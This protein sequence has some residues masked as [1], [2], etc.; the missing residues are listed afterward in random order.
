M[1]ITRIQLVLLFTIEEVLHIITQMRLTIHESNQ[2]MRY[3]EHHCKQSSYASRNARLVDIDRSSMTISS[4]RD[5]SHKIPI[6]PPIS[7]TREARE[8][9]IEMDRDAM[10]ALGRSD[11]SVREYRAPRGFHA[12]VFWACVFTFALLFRRQNLLPGS[13]VHDAVLRYVPSFA[14]FLVVVRPWVFGGMVAS[15]LTEATFMA[16]TRLRK[17]SVPFGSGLWWTWMLSTF[18]EG[19]GAFQRYVLLIAS[20]FESSLI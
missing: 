15:H 7:S 10:K 11:I 2:V 4:S 17:H 20:A 9:L 8:R 5:Q 12:V 14:H 18:I 19:F 16:W 1:R 13:W 3:L 6:Q